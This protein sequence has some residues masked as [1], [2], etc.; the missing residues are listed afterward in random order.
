[1]NNLEFLAVL[2]SILIGVIG[3]S[4]SIFKLASF[5]ADIER[6]I[7]EKHDEV[8]G[9]LRLANQTIQLR[10]K[11]FEGEQ[12]QEIYRFRVLESQIQELKQHQRQLENFMAQHHG[13][14]KRPYNTMENTQGRRIDREP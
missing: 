12:K 1:M 8:S 14:V 6:K 9:S 13:F 2:V 7:D 5:K 11:E 3:I 4:S 10:L